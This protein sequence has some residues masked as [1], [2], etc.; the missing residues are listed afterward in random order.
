MEM[1]EFGDLINEFEHALLSIDRNKAKSILT[2]TTAE[3]S[4]IQFVDGLV[5]PVLERIGEQWERDEVALSQVYVSGKICE[6]LIDVILP[7][8]GQQRRSRPKIAI[9]VLQDYHA[10]GKRIVYSML[11]AYG[12]ELADY[13]CGMTV[14]DLARRTAEDKIEILLVSVLMMRSALRVKD[15]RKALHEIGANPK[16]VVGGAPF[17][18]NERLWQQVDADAMGK[19]AADAIDIVSEMVKEVE[20]V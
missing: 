13:G 14:E 18:L 10:L 1:M 20:A 5:V 11:R 7:A 8:S 6:E 17:R 2:T 3:V 15:L 9:A 16:I 12:F 4:P 19:N